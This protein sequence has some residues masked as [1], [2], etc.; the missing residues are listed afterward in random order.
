MPDASIPLL[1]FDPRERG[2]GDV[3]R[4]AYDRVA[5][6]VDEH[7]TVLAVST[8]ALT[9]LAAWQ[10]V[11]EI[12]VPTWA[13]VGLI[14]LGLSA[15]TS[16]YLGRGLARGLHARETVLIRELDAKTGDERLIELAPD[17]FDDLTV[18]TQYGDE[19][20]RSY[21]TRVSI[22][23]RTAYEVDKYVDDVNLAYASWQAGAS[24][25]ELRASRKRID[26]IKTELEAEADKSLEL[27][28][29]HPSILREQAKTV[30]MRILRVAEGVDVPGGDSLHEDLAERLDDADP[31]S[32]LLGEVPEGESEQ[33]RDRHDAPEDG[34]PATIELEVTDDDD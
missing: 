14:G 4:D 26:D 31:S 2:P 22:N 16:W 29:N 17:T 27:L 19:R 1:P 11:P 18:T 9:G 21:L 8:V 5:R 15:A 33:R 28:A 3:V 7:F 30:S 23:G 6:V 20:D 25:G 12:G 10:G 13:K 32:D 34:D 24:N